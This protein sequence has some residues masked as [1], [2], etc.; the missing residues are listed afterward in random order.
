MKHCEL[1]GEYAEYYCYIMGLVGGPEW[2]DDMALQM[3]RLF[4]RK[5]YWVNRLDENL[6]IK[7]EGLRKRFAG[8]G[9]VPEGEMSVLEVLIQLALDVDQWMM[10]NPRYGS[11]AAYFFQEILGAAGLDVD[12]SCLDE[13]IDEFLD[14]KVLLSEYAK[15]EQTL[16]LQANVLFGEQFD[17][18]NESFQW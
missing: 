10:S 1:A 6:A 14:G 16:W 5:Y 3:A 2:W 13:R 9:P 4:S 8:A 11:R 17:V 12:I 15:P 18:E 7:A